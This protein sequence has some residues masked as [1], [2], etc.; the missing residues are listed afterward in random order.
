MEMNSMYMSTCMKALCRHVNKNK[1]QGGCFGGDGF[2]GCNL[3]LML[4]LMVV[5]ATVLVVVLLLLSNGYTNPYEEIDGQSLVWKTNPCF[6]GVRAESMST[7]SGP[8]LWWRVPK[9]KTT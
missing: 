1:Q 8:R 2:E 9:T 4:M 5:V 7:I 3:M 6:D